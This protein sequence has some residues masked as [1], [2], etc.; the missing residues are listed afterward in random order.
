MTGAVREEASMDTETREAIETEVHNCTNSERSAQPI[1]ELDNSDAVRKV[2]EAI[3]AQLDPPSSDDVPRVFMWSGETVPSSF[4]HKNSSVE[5]ILNAS[6]EVVIV[7]LSEEDSLVQPSRVE[8]I[9][10]D[11]DDCDGSDEEESESEEEEGSAKSMEDEDREAEP[12][13]S[14]ASGSELEPGGITDTTSKKKYSEPSL[15]L[16]AILRARKASS[17]SQ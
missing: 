7:T 2:D 3:A 15:P 8:G 1:D 14:I 9:D 5:G 11:P 13:A 4:A 17:S 12:D 16:Q 6:E 10:T